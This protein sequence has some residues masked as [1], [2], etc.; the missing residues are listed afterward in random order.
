MRDILIFDRLPKKK[1][2]VRLNKPRT[3]S[4]RYASAM[5]DCYEAN[6]RYFM[7]NCHKNPNL[8]I[9]HGEVS[10]QGD[11]A[12][13][14]FGHCWVVDGENVLDFS[15]GRDIRISKMIYY[16]IGNVEW[17]NNYHVYDCR[18][19]HENLD[20][21]GHWGCWDLKTKSGL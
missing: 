12:G 8:R 11:L 17:I 2:P 5:G 3:R 9:V 15:N 6:G 18:T 13:T 1:T 20:K 10:G 21:W 14:T 7:D 4:M 16:A 19:F